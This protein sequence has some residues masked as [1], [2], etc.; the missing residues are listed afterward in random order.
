[1]EILT[2]RDRNGGFE[3]QI[4]KKYQT[5]MSDEIEEKII[6]LYALGMSYKDISGHIRELYGIGL[7]NAAISNITDKIIEKVGEW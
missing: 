3:P 5:T 6:S 2:P 7:S 1:M 4:V